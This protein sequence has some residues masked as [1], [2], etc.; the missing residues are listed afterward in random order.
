MKI[1]QVVPVEIVSADS[2]Q[3]YRYMDIGTAKPSREERAEVPHHLVDIIEPDDEFSL[4]EYI[5][6]AKEAIKIAKRHG[7]VP[8]LVGGTGQYVMA[9]LEGWNVPPVPPDPAVR[10]RLETQLATDGLQPLLDELRDLDPAGLNA[11]DQKNP[12]RVIRAIERAS[13]GYLWG[14][15]PNSEEPSFES[16]MIGI[17]ADRA[18]LYARADGRLDSMMANGFLKEVEWLLNAGYSPELPAMSGIGYGELVDHLMKGTDLQAAVQRAKNRTHRY[19]RQQSNWFKASDTRIKWFEA[20]E[21]DA[22]IP[23]AQEWLA[24]PKPKL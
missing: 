14:A 10:T 21:A 20:P 12:R 6:H 22:G 1:A 24:S 5:Y 13:A 8:L 23:Y 9:L 4:R 3:V 7:N 15:Q 17:G 19:I 11:V 18:D 2:R 16:L